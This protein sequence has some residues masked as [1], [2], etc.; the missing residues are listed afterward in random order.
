MAGGRQCS[1]TKAAKVIGA[2]VGIVCNMGEQWMG[3]IR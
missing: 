3:K 2:G 1:F